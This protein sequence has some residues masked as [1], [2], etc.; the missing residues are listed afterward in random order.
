[1]GWMTMLAGIVMLE[2]KD[3]IKE[4][5]LMFL[6]SYLGLA[7]G[8]SLLV[9]LVKMIAKEWA[10]EKAPALTIVFTF[11]LGPA[12]KCLVPDV[13]GPQTWKAWT[14]HAVILI[15]V[16]VI[17]AVFHDKFW[18]VVKGK[19]GALIPG[20]LDTEEKPPSPPGGSG[21]EAEKK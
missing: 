16:A 15:F 21:G 6:A 7:L 8:V 1:M 20:G 10:K 5:V 17:A 9:E 4:L 14:L 19:L 18:N 13:Y 12:A 11:I 2:E 3:A